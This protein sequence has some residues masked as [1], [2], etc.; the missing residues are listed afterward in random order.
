[1]VFAFGFGADVDARFHVW[2]HALLIQKNDG[3]IDF[4][5]LELI[6][7]HSVPHTRLI[8]GLQNA[9]YFSFEPPSRMRHGPRLLSS[10]LEDSADAVAGAQRDRRERDYGVNFNQAE[11]VTLRDCG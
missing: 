6:G 4:A 7:R 2:H 11:A 9:L 5:F 3:K 8:L 10:R 1:M